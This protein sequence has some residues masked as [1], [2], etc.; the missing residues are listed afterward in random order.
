MSNL[1]PY[2]LKSSLFFAVLIVFYGLFLRKET[3]HYFK[4]FVLFSIPFLAFLTPL[5]HFT[6][7]TK[8]QI[9]NGFAIHK[10]I[11]LT[12]ETQ[13]AGINWQQ[14]VL[15]LIILGSCVFFVLTVIGLVRVISII[16]QS[17]KEQLAVGVLCK[18]KHSISPF[19]FY[20]Y[21]VIYPNDYSNNEFEQIIEHE[22]V[23]VYQKHM[24][25]ML[26]S[27][28]LMILFWWNPL[29]WMY[30]HYVIENLEFIVDQEVLQTGIDKKNYQL[31]ILSTSVSNQSLVFANHFNHSLIKNRIKMMNKQLSNPKTMWRAVLIVPLLFVLLIAM[32]NISTIAT[33]RV[34]S[35]ELANALSIQELTTP[36]VDTIPAKENLNIQRFGEDYNTVIYVDGH[37]KTQQQLD[38]IDSDE[39][40][41][42]SIKKD[43]SNNNGVVTKSAE[44]HVKTK[45]YASNKKAGYDYPK[46]NNS[47][48]GNGPAGLSSADIDGAKIIID[49]KEVSKEEIE[50]MN[51]DDIESISIIRFNKDEGGETKEIRILSKSNSKD[52]DLAN[53]PFDAEIYVNGKLVDNVNAVK[54]S[55]IKSMT[56]TTNEENGKKRVVIYTKSLN[57]YSKKELKEFTKRNILPPPPP[58]AP[59]TPPSTP[60]KS[61]SSISYK[62]GSL[63]DIS[64]DALIYLDGKLVSDINAIEPSSINNIVVIKDEKTGEKKVAIYSKTYNEYSKDELKTLKDSGFLPP[65]PPPSPAPPTFSTQAYDYVEQSPVYEKGVTALVK[66]LAANFVVPDEFANANPT[67]NE[68]VILRFVVL[69]DGSVGETKVIRGIKDCNTCN[70]NAIKAVKSLPGK[71]QP[72]MQDGKPVNTF[73][74][75]PFNLKKN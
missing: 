10:V 65:P 14:I 38:E 55:E 9:F 59:P 51:N 40:A 63:S 68:M 33:N 56:M 34:E 7:P 62:T 31:A 30:R 11:E 47:S 13:S 23:H 48:L 52:A 70:E 2:L 75:V 64:S 6:L 45:N 74:T 71:F 19:S 26:L 15:G 73:L 67:Y 4:R 43:K 24:I 22:Q 53:L 3:I 32:G 8:Q 46:S 36:V 16:L 25:D 57:E 29:V 20:N 69:K 41:E 27:Q 42:I 37:V 17:N 28:V 12:S 66:D 54:P 58:P 61:D 50:Q 39:I 1:F 21:I 49:G 44:I 60:K 35:N 5:V 72:G 18:P